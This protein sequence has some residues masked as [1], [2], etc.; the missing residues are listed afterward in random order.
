MGEGIEFSQGG[1]VSDSSDDA[2][3]S[4]INR[5]LDELDW[6]LVDLA[7]AT[8]QSYRNVHRWVRDDVKVP[9]HFITR[10]AEVVPVDPRWLLTG[11]GTPERIEESTAQWALER[12][13]DVLDS[14]RATSTP[15]V[16]S[17]S[18]IGSSIDGI[19][20]FDRQLRYTLWNPAMEEITGVSARAVLGKEVLD[21]FPEVAGTDLE[22]HFRGAVE[23][24]TSTM[25]ERPYSLSEDRSGW[26]EARCFPL[27]RPSGETIG[28]VCIVRDVTERRKAVLQK[29][30]S[31]ERYSVLLAMTGQPAFLQV[32]G[33][34]VE[35][36]GPLEALAGC[37]DA[38]GLTGMAVGELLSL[39]NGGSPLLEELSGVE[40]GQRLGPKRVLLNRRDASVLQVQLLAVGVR[41]RGRP[42][43][44]ALLRVPSSD[45]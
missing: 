14:I 24:R 28:G 18:V 13:S 26:Y 29:E 22:R 27:R 36:N 33:E 45:E 20:A 16:L 44:Q 37:D 11:E 15:G 40:V 31:E 21:V 23:G 25:S 32:E 41:F 4:R 12:I 43:A 19:V 3:K 30:E 35:A 9:A 39:E 2:I 42:A 17:E 8:G 10:F 7:D 1:G 6:S 5:R 38:G 34:V